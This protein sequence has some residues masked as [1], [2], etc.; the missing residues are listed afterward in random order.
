VWASVL[1]VSKA[2][3]ALVKKLDRWN[4]WEQPVSQAQKHLQQLQAQ[5]L[6]LLRQ[7]QYK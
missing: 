7:V 4:Q 6:H 3:L 5:Q 2:T 1:Q